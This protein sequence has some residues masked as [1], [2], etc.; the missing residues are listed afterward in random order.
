MISAVRSDNVPNLFLLQYTDVWIVKNLLLVPYFFFTES[1]IQRRK[2]LGPH[3]RRAGW[4]GCN[5]LLSE[6]P[7]DGKLRIITEGV[8]ANPS[9]LRKRF[10][11]VRPLS[12]LGSEM[13][14]WTLEV[15]RAI[16]QIDRPEFTLDEI[17]EFEPRLSLAHPKN[18][19]VR[20]KIRQQLQKLRDFDF[21]EFVSPGRYRVL[22]TA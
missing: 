7:P 4:I 9:E 18:R 3:A 22:K 20:P 15:L 16:R 11:Q 10:D 21:L 12:R 13:R 14:G 5:I 6:I 17:Y 2:P 8:T 19:N 1:V